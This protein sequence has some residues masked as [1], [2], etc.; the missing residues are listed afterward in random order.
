MFKL[1]QKA[2]AWSMAFAAI[3]TAAS[4]GTAPT[5]YGQEQAVET[6]IVTG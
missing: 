1:N 2:S 4:L 5:V 3:A 6:V